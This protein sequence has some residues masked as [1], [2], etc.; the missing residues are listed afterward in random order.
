MFSKDEKCRRNSLGSGG[1]AT[2]VQEPR[3]VTLNNGSVSI[4]DHTVA[5]KCGDFDAQPSSPL[6]ISWIKAMYSRLLALSSRKRTYVSLLKTQ[7]RPSHTILEF[8]NMFR[9]CCALVIVRRF[10]AMLTHIASALFWGRVE[11]LGCYPRQVCCVPFV[12]GV[13]ILLQNVPTFSGS[14][15]LWFCATR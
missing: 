1:G 2:F 14:W 5:M 10:V 3:S 11:E 13:I 6:C 4:E 9:F 8:E 12:P 7:P 15:L